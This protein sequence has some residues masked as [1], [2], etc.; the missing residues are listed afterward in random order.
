MDAYLGE[1]RI[2]CGTFDPLHWQ[3]CAGQL[4]SIQSNTA[5]FSILGTMYGGDGRVTFGLP[6]LG[7]AVPLGQGQGP[8]LTMRYVGE[9][10]G[11]ANVNLQ[12]A[13]MPAHKHAAMGSS[14]VGAANS[15]AGATWTTYGTGRPVS[16]DNLYGATSDVTMA[17]DALMPAGQSMPHNNMQPFLAMRFMI[18]TNGLF[19]PRQ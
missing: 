5:L 2:F 17:S 18:C 12:A 8:G 1:I 11:A 13:E 19:P 9:T 7:G 16:L 3:V 15:P 14:Q 6:N 4:M 10:G